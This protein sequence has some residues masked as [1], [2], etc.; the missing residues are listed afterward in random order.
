M[1]MEPALSN[2]ERLDGRTSSA[3]ADPLCAQLDA[4]L[5]LTRWIERVMMTGFASV[6]VLILVKG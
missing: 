4:L 3:N 5:V 1:P 6:I 2:D